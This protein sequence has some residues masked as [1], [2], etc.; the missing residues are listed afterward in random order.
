MFHQAFR[1]ELTTSVSL[2][3]LLYLPQGY[4][5]REDWPLIL[6]LHGRGERGDDLNLVKLH[7]L[8]RLIEAGEHYPFV[9]VAPQCPA[10]GL[11]WLDQIETLNALLDDVIARYDVDPKRVYLTGLSMGGGG[12]W[13]LAGRYPER[14]AAIAPICGSSLRPL[15]D[16]LVKTPAWVFHG[17]S[18]AI[19]PLAQSQQMVHALEELGGNVRFTVYPDVGHNSWDLTYSNPELFTWF[20]SHALP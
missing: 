14:F 11:W 19:V 20:L 3:Y 1:T 13:F 4:E 6:F 5:S 17:D 2:N 16:Q 10:S 8:P 12:T 9:I 18:D 7:G 15:A